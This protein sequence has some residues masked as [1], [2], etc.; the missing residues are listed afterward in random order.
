MGARGRD[1]RT[2]YDADVQALLGILSHCVACAC[3][4]LNVGGAAH[5]KLG[6]VLRARNA[7]AHKATLEM[8]ESEAIACI[9]AFEALLLHLQGV[10]ADTS[11]ATSLALSSEAVAELTRAAAEAVNALR[12][13][14][15]ATL[16]T[17]AAEV[18]GLRA[19]VS[20]V[21][22][23]IAMEDGDA[24]TADGTLRAV[25][26]Q[27]TA[28]GDRVA[29]VEGEAPAGVVDGSAQLRE[30]LEE[31]RLA[32]HE[33]LLA[34]EA[35]VAGNRDAIEST[36]NLAA[37]H[38]EDIAVLHDR[39]ASIEHTRSGAMDVA[40][41]PAPF[42]HAFVSAATPCHLTGFEPALRRLRRR[43]QPRSEP[44]GSPHVDD[45]AAGHGTCAPSGM[46]GWHA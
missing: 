23:A 3:T 12:A 40:S 5:A 22:A 24:R 6:A 46:A 39:V 19:Q 14:R 29:A 41:T 32:I 38:S 26:E 16:F 42:P 2:P 11:L 21:M 7:C 30:E 25:Q 31:A 13:V 18:V 10:I 44:A 33:R 9:D 43:L 45:D 35:G 4:H 1:C 20:A 27:L 37:E 15:G 28:L 17:P 34:I 36:A 8:G